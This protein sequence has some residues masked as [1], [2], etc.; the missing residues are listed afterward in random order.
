[1][2]ERDLAERTFPMISADV[3]RVAAKVHPQKLILFHLSDRY[4]PLEWREQ[5]AKVQA[6]FPETHFP[7]TWDFQAEQT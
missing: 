4:T 1:M 7:G 3:A 6:L 5:L 2:R